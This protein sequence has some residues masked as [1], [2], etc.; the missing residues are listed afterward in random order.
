MKTGKDQFKNFDAILIKYL[1]GSATIEERGSALNFINEDTEHQKYFDELKDYYQLTKVIQNPSGFN[2]EKAWERVKEEYAKTKYTAELHNK[3]IQ[4]IRRLIYISVSSAA[5]IF[6]S[7]FL[8]SYLNKQSSSRLENSL[9]LT[10]NQIVVPLGAKSQVILSDGS[11]VWLNAGSKLRYPIN[12]LSKNREVFLEG[13]A[14]FDITKIQHK[15]FIVRTS[16]L[17]IKVYGTQFNVKAYSDENQI[18]TTLVKGSVALEPSL[19]NNNNT[20]Y[21][22]KPN[23]TATYFKST[24]TVKT[25]NTLQP[26]SVSAINK[27]QEKIFVVDKIDPIPIISWKDKQ[28]VLDGEELAQLA[29]KL[30]RRYNVKIFFEDVSLKSYKFSGTLTDETF[31]QVLKIIQLSAPILFFVDGNKV[32]F[33][34]NI[35]FKKK[36]DQMILKQ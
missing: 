29:V 5:A 21:F 9:P 28:W 12:F 13:E 1:L 35:M 22:L 15:Q 24:S 27:M 36:Y 32:V 2:K 17:N 34:E 11:K 16:N 26:S 20:V 6:I 33:R 4:Y 8:G 30:E 19:D 31:E 23:Q 18:Q 3:K 25:A 14:F 7:F 10:Y